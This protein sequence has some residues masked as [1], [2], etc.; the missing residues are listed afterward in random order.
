MRRIILMAVAL[1]GIIMTHAADPTATN[2]TWNEC[3]GSSRPYPAP[4]EVVVTADERETVSAPVR[5]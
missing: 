3:Q 4:K 1:S 5:D 2:Y